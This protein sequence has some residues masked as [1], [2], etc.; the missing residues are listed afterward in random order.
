MWFGCRGI[1]GV[2]ASVFAELAQA[3]PAT[4]LWLFIKRD[5]ATPVPACSAC[6]ALHSALACGGAMANPVDDAAAAVPAP[7]VRGAVAR[8]C[9]A[10]NHQE[11]D[12]IRKAVGAADRV[13]SV[14]LGVDAAGIELH[15]V[16]DRRRKSNPTASRSI[17]S[18]L[19]T[20]HMLA[21]RGRNAAAPRLLRRRR[22]ANSECSPWL[23][24]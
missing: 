4:G 18:A 7:G 3:S 16:G 8:R 2:G 11:F 22:R 9:T 20:A 13:A 24:L 23:S 6:I 10:R 15:I 12:C 1:V 14:E 17:R 21:F 19:H 5:F